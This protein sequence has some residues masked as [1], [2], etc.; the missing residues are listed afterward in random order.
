MERKLIT[1]TDVFLI[2]FIVLITIGYFV[3]KSFSDEKAFAEIYFD[4][5]II[6]TVNLAEK[7]EKKIVTGEN[8]SVVIVAKD[9]KIYFEESSCPDKVCIKSGEL[10]ENGDFASC[11]PEKVVIKVSGAEGNEPDAI[12]Y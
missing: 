11:L 9:G 10:S 12:V 5:E 6:E 3:F 4:G 2:L 8:S 1:K 7:E